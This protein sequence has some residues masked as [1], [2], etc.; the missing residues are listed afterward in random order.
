MR[1]FILLFAIVLCGFVPCPAADNPAMGKWNCTSADAT[2]TRIT[3]TL[4]VKQENGKL[5]G[6]LLGENSEELPLI[7]PAVEGRTFTFKLRINA[8]ETVEV[9]VEIDGDKF[10]GKFQ[11]KQSGTG[12]FQGTR[13]A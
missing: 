10:D 2:G 9:K 1:A 3:W 4:L 11:G 8:E 5:S 12:T 7:E 13:Q 6:S